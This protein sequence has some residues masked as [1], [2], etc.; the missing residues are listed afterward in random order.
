MVAP[1]PAGPTLLQAS[2]ASRPDP[3]KPSAKPRSEH[4]RLSLGEIASLRAQLHYRPEDEATILEE[5]EIEPDAWQAEDRRADRMLADAA[6]RGDVAV[7][8]AF[9]DAY[10]AQLDTERGEA[11][12]AQAYAALELSVERDRTD[13]EL[14]RQRIP[15]DAFFPVKRR[16]ARAMIDD[17]ALRRDFRD[18]LETARHA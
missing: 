9:D 11:V 13:V 18:A 1:D 16:W 7:L 2:A 17:P 12:D 6:Q 4:R 15:A 14:A 8:A 3:S 5:T 10:C